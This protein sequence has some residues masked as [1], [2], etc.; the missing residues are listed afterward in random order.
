MT[1]DE[2]LR[3]LDDLLQRA[4][5]KPLND[6]QRAI[7]RGAWG[8]QSYKEIRQDC[9]QVSLEHIMR[10]VGP[11]LWQWLSRVATEQVGE[12]IKFRKE[13]LRGPLERIRDRRPPPHLSPPPIADL[14]VPPATLP[15]SSALPAPP[16]VFE[17]SEFEWE[18]QRVNRAQDWGDAPA[19]SQFQGRSQELA[20]LYQWVEE[21]GCRVLSLTGA[22]GIGKTDLSVKVA[23][24]LRDGFEWTIWRSLD[25]ALTGC[26]P[27][28]LP[29]LLTDVLTFL[30]GAAP[31]PTLNTLLEVLR[32]QRCLIVLDGFE[33]VLQGQVLS[34]D[35]L[36]GYE[37]YSDLLKRLSDT[38]HLSCCLITSRE[39]PREIQAREGVK[40]LVRSH[41]LLGLAPEEVE[42]L[43]F[44]KG[45]FIATE[46][47]WRSL[48]HQYNG[49]PGFLQPVATTITHAFGR[50]VS[51]F[52]AYQPQQAMFVGEMRRSFDQQ[53]ARLSDPEVALLRELAK[54]REPATLEDMQ[55]RMQA[56]MSAHQLL[57]VLLSLVRRS[58]LRPSA[59]AY[60]LNPL[61][62]EYL[63][64]REWSI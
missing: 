34:G 26:A 27:P 52:L 48:A 57:E 28:P 33:A 8:G 5:E 38:Q 51:R 1:A 35:Y 20:M 3:L 24:R 53:V 22:A 30:T 25:P 13:S 58:L 29:E 37:A 54:H 61:M 43:F 18:T 10:N 11:D 46:T 16:D 21:E 2:A 32:R 63:T 55:S 42:S 64:Q 9:P 59:I 14:D 15:S 40:T 36:P 31:T 47:D 12:P 56:V 62:A 44:A 17:L 41:S 23:E 60:S 4:G 49:N 45:D 50:D 39:Q 6:L 19:A 7:F